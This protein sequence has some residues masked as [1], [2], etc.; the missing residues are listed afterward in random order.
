M[1]KNYLNITVSICAIALGYQSYAQAPSND[2]PCNA[3]FI[4]AGASC[5]FST[6]TN[7][8]ATG[9]ATVPA[10]P[11]GFYTGADVWFKSTV[12]ASGHLIFESSVGVMTDGAMAVYSGSCPSL[13]LINCDDDSG[14]GFMPK[15]DVCY[16][17]TGDTVWIRFWSYN[18]IDDGTFNICIY[19]GGTC[20]P[21]PVNDTCLGAIAVSVAA[22]LA[23]CTPTNVNTTF[24]TG[25]SYAS[26]C[27]VTFYD[28]DVWY[29]FTATAP[30]VFLNISN[31]SVVG[32][33]VGYSIFQDSCTAAEFICGDDV[34]GSTDSIGGLTI[35][36]TYYISIFYTGTTDRGTFDL[37]LANNLA[38]GIPPID[39]IRNS[40]QIYP[41]PATDNL[42]LNFKT[43]KTNDLAI[44]LFDMHGKEVYAHSERYFSGEFN[45]SI[46]LSRMSRG[47]YLLQIISDNSAVTKKIAIQ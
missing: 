46:D 15:L 11:C 13:T 24:G 8:G 14:P 28:D 44:K 27:S 26:F 17:T 18:G 2:E 40:L 33:N 7:S 31:K 42:T 34:S 16:L 23:S 30:Y 37:C 39:A 1:K 45:K 47:I 38:V 41:N 32:G 36:K 21:P 6:F 35:G 5:A 19:D 12:P 4:S 3:I 10:P 22:S 43:G 29:K 9:T 25:S 20:L